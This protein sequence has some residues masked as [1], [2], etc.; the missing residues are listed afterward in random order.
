MRMKCDLSLQ[1]MALFEARIALTLIFGCFN[2]LPSRAVTVRRVDEKLTVVPQNVI[3][4]VTELILREN[5]IKIL[6]NNSFRRYENITCISLKRN[7]VWK[8]SDGTFENNPLLKRF[9]CIGC[10]LRVLPPSFGPAMSK[11]EYLYLAGGLRDI[12]IIKSPYFDSFLSMKVIHLG[13]NDLYDVD[14]II[15]PPSLQF[16]DLFRVR[17]SHFPN[18]SVSRFPS[19]RGLKLGSNYITNISNSALAVAN[20]KFRYLSIPWTR[21]VQIGD[22]TLLSALEYIDLRFNELATIPDMMGLTNLETIMATGN[23]R[24]TCDRRMCW[25]RL[26][27]RVRLWLITDSI[28]CVASSDVSGHLLSQI[29]PGFMQCDQGKL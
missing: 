24:M 13:R 29:S 18:I 11:I 4:S 23:T 19:L 22:L 28:Q 2:Q 20:N 3:A 27:N 8:I 9:D 1:D 14:N 5:L 6:Y 12:S 10:V 25:A 26:W 15:F 21:L 16:V 17:L 7:P